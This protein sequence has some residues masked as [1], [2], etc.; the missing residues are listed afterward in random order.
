MIDT[1]I[2]KSL[3]TVVIPTFNR[4]SSI[5]VCI[6]S[7]LA[8]TYENLEIIISDDCSTDDTV[9]IVESYASRVKLIR[10]IVN[11]GPS[12]AR[13]AAIR[14]ARGEIIFFTD[15]DVKVE[16]NW[17]E[18]GVAYFDDIRVVGIEGRVI[19]VREGYNERYGDR[20]VRNSEG[21]VYMTA[22]AAYRKAA[23]LEH[24]LFD[25][26]LRK[27]QDRELALRMLKIG[28][29]IYAPDAIVVHRLER[30]DVSG[31]MREAD[32]IQYWL[33][34]MRKTGESKHVWHHVYS[35]AKLLALAFP[36]AMLFR[37]FTHDFKDRVDWTMFLL[38]YPRL[39]YERVL[40]WRYAL[41]NRMFI[42]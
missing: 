20:P 2:K 6:E 18:K 21:G 33:I 34:L 3:I 32:K 19:Y 7:L 30:Y 41:A 25:L 1:P 11:G 35:P 40:L 37:L 8:Q 9:R 27:Y 31:F 15:D 10:S 42:I 16:N 23:L 14:E 12:A 13:N 4:S 28:T 5:R 22:N 26:T 17:V 24:G 36:P 39:W 29:I 38:S